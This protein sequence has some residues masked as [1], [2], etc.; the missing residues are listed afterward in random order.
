MPCGVTIKRFLTVRRNPPV[1]PPHALT[2]CIVD[3]AITGLA[4]AT[5]HVSTGSIMAQSAAPVRATGMAL[6]QEPRFNKST[7]FTVEEREALG[8][9]GLL[10]DV[11]ESED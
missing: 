7:A 11:V 9:T 3:R 2:E 1:G 8:L 10:P 6:L 5:L 4:P